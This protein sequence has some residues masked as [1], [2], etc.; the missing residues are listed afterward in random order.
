MKLYLFHVNHTHL[1]TLVVDRD[2]MDIE[3]TYWSLKGSN[4]KFDL[5]VLENIISPPFPQS[6]CQSEYNKEIRP[7]KQ[8]LLYL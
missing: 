5:T 3:K 4:G 2:I 6:L 8:I 1:I 7:F